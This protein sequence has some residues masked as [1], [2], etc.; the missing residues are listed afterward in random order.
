[1]PPN[2]LIFCC[3]LLLLPSIFPSIRVSSNELALCNRWP[4]FWSFSFSINTSN[5]YSRMI[6]FKIHWFV[7]LPV[8]AIL[9]VI[10]E[11]SSGFPHFFNLSLNLV[12]R[13][14]W[15]EPQSTPSLV[16]ADY[17]ASPSCVHFLRKMS[18]LVYS[19]P[20]GSVQSIGT[21][22][23]CPIRAAL[24]SVDEKVVVVVK[25][26]YFVMDLYYCTLQ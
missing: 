17:R 3:S 6:S 26:N 15:S 23:D 4:K 19:F 18:L 24:N 22:R 2:H 7:L 14:S 8:Q 12:I 21:I 11:W 13:S 10:P 25:K 5:A 9:K 20:R 16:F 1:M